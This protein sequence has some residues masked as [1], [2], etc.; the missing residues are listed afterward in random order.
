MGR[1]GHHVRQRTLTIDKHTLCGARSKATVKSTENRDKRQYRR[2]DSSDLSDGHTVA[3][4]T[5]EHPPQNVTCHEEFGSTEPVPDG[6]SRLAGAPALDD[7]PNRE[8]LNG[9]TA[10]RRHRGAETVI[11]DTELPGFGLR[12]YPSGAK[13]WIVRYIERGKA[14]VWTIGSTSVVDAARARRAAR[15]R[16]QDAILQGLP[17]KPAKSAQSRAPTFEAVCAVFGG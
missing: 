16:L 14:R 7:S 9:N 3:D 1:K 8:R 13:R 12:C 11:W 2:L 17:R 4:D 6:S 15:K 5:G 10:R